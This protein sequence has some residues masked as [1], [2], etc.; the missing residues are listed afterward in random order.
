MGPV[1][2]WGAVTQLY[3]PF[4]LAA[5]LFMSEKRSNGSL[6]AFVLLFRAIGLSVNFS[7]AVQ[8]AP[9]GITRPPW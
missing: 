7:G 4:P 2:P 9:S 6:S 3:P 8:P 5:Q 1:F